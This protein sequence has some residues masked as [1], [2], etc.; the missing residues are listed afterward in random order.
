MD[1]VKYNAGIVN[2]SQATNVTAA[3]GLPNMIALS[4]YPSAIIATFSQALNI[5][6]TIL[7]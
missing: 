4:L 3:V 6:N 1:L 5:A 7:A 2:L